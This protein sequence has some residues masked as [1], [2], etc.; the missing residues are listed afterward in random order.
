MKINALGYASTSKS[1]DILDVYYPRI[2]FNGNEVN[3]LDLKNI[4][5]SKKSIGWRS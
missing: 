3:A 1:G 2:E 4:S 5:S